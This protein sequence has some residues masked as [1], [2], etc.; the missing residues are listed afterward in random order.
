[1]GSF[2]PNPHYDRITKGLDE[3][4]HRYMI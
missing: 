2:T 1:M 3:I 4:I